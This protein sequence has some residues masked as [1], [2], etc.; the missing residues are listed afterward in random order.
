MLAVFVFPSG[1]SRNNGRDD[2]SKE[3][4]TVNSSV[5][6]VSP[7]TSLLSRLGGGVLFLEWK[8][9]RILCSFSPKWI[10]VL[11]GRFSHR[12]RIFCVTPF[13]MARGEIMFSFGGSACRE[14]SRTPASNIS[15]V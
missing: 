6:W 13:S 5:N 8:Q 3:G 7:V 12:I 15:E 9:R 14:D 10:W 11:A 1:V 2:P 4:G